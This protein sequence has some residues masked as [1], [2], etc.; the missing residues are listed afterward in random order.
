MKKPL[1]PSATVVLFGEIGLTHKWSR[2]LSSFIMFANFDRVT[3]KVLN[4]RIFLLR[5]LA[6]NFALMKS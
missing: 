4:N 6:T 3:L 5:I 1:L 2:R